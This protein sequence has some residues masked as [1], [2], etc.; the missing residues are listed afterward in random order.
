MNLNNSYTSIKMIFCYDSKDVNLMTDRITKEQR[1][2]IMSSIKSNSRLENELSRALWKKGI[3][4]RKNVKSL[5]GTPDI[6]IKKYK[7][8]IF[9]DSCF[10]HC[11]PIHGN[12][13]KS[14]VEFWEKKLNRNRER[15][16]EVNEYYKDKGWTVIRIWEHEIRDDLDNVICNLVEE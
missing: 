10:W 2:H 4:F 3:R 13:P 12:K 6:A 15:D 1:S 14:N 5:Y 7:I 16:Q 9:V 8:V 11:C